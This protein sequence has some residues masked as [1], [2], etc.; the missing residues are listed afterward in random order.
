[1]GGV[2]FG[3]QKIPCPSIRE[4]LGQEAQVGGW[5]AGGGGGYREFLEEKLGKE[6]AFEM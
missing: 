5:G 2:A 1:M 6:I 4:C 3:L